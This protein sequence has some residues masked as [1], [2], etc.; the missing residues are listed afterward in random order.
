VVVVSKVFTLQTSTVHSGRNH[1]WLIH[2]KTRRTVNYKTSRTPCGHSHAISDLRTVRPLPRNFRLTHCAATPTQFQTYA[3]CGHSHAI[4]DLR[5]VR[6]LPRNFR[7]THCAATPTQFQTY[8]PC[9]HSHA[10]SDLR[11]VRSLP[12]NFRL[13][14]RAATPTQ[15]QTYAP[16]G[17]SHAISDLKKVWNKGNS[18][19]ENRAGFFFEGMKA[20]WDEGGGRV[21][22]G[23]NTCGG[24]VTL[25]PIR[26]QC[27]GVWI[28]TWLCTWPYV[29]VLSTELRKIW[30]A[31]T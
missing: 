12:R 18:I 6:P 21:L 9:G 27:V 10:I 13:T 29:Y 15:F 20:Q 28:S 8:A 1:P 7:L 11:T 23:D 2:K 25:L 16:C 24:V 22:L 4:S 26:F 14:H 3:P 5:T 30:L 31:M 17:H 19:L